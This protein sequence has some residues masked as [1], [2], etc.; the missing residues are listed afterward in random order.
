MQTAPPRNNQSAGPSP[1]RAAGKAERPFQGPRG[2]ATA[3]AVAAA[4]HWGP[5]HF[6][7]NLLNPSPTVMPPRPTCS[8]RESMQ[9]AGAA[10]DDGNTWEGAPLPASLEELDDLI[11]LAILRGVQ[12]DACL[13]HLRV[14]GVAPCRVAWC[15]APRCCSA[16]PLEHTRLSLAGRAHPP[17]RPKPCRSSAGGCWS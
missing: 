9:P 7:P 6:F 5:L 1:C 8:A 14:S 17:S 2:A 11:L 13:L 10:E 3:V 15:A 16:S 4:R 12:D